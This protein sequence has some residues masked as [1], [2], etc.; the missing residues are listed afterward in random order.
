MTNFINRLRDGENIVL[1]IGDILG[2]LM[3]YP[4]KRDLAK[5]VY[6]DLDKH[7]KLE[8]SN[9]NSLAEVCQVYLDSVTGSKLKLLNKL[10]NSYL[11]SQEASDLF[12][13]FPKS[14]FISAVVTTNLDTFI[15]NS[16]GKS[17]QKVEVQSKTVVGSELPRLYK[18]NGDFEHLD[19]MLVTKQDLRKLKTLSLYN[20]LFENLKRELENK[21]LLFIGY[22][23]EDPDTKEI[24]SFVYSKLGDS[25]PNAYFVTSSSIISTDTINWLNSNEIKLLKQNETEFLDELK[26]YL[27]EE[28]HIPVTSDAQ[29]GLAIKKKYQ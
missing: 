17:I 6:N 12:Q 26:K 11:N 7:S 15:E 24:L 21:L 16:Y 28:K 29:E 13:L 18:I 3:G 25:K 1:W 14:P 20:P 8:V 22:D 19:K 23:L 4:S 27:T 9:I 5:L 2:K 10:K